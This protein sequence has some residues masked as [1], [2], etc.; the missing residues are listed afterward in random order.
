M[1]GSERTR[2]ESDRSS[3]GYRTGS[4]ESDC[5]TTGA[6]ETTV[7]SEADERTTEHE[8]DKKTVDSGAD[9]GTTEPGSEETTVDSGADERTTERESEEKTVDSEIGTPG[10]AEGAS[11]DETATTRNGS[12]AGTHT[13]RFWQTKIA[14]VAAGDTSGTGARTVSSASSGMSGGLTM[15][16]KAVTV[17]TGA[18]ARFRGLATIFRSVTLWQV[19]HIAFIVTA[20]ATVLSV[21]A[22][23]ATGGGLS[24]PQILVLIGEFGVGIII[25]AIDLLSRLRQ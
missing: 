3:R 16:R 5:E 2:A 8:S 20:V 18:L 7:D 17:A 13:Q 6:D 9:E 1:R 25:A 19:I 12:T 23:T 24:A 11:G 15:W 21:Y 4:A 10:S 22:V 14:G